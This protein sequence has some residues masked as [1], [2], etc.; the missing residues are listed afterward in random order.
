MGKKETLVVL[1]CLLSFG[2]ISQAEN[3]DSTFVKKG[4]VR[5]FGCFAFDYRIADNV[6]DYKLHGFL[7]YFPEKKVSVLGELYYFLD[8]SED[9]PVIKSHWSTGTGLAYHWPSKRLDPYVFFMG[10]GHITT[11]Q[12]MVSDSLV[13]E[14]YVNANEHLNPL[15]ALGGGCNLYVWKYLNFFVQ[16]RYTHTF[17]YSAIHI[18]N[19][20]SFSVSYGLGFNFHT[21]KKKKSHS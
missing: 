12:I 9:L 16:F 20:D 3:D 4:L 19:M 7:E 10:G 2:G 15:V 8:S 17:I 14:E 18:R 5:F 6:W 11:S 21:R 13:Q 1:L